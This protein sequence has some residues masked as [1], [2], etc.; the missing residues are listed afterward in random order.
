MY[1]YEILYYYKNQE[2]RTGYTAFFYDLF[3]KNLCKLG[4]IKT[5]HCIARLINYNIIK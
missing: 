4:I 2:L 1:K 5:C 3:S